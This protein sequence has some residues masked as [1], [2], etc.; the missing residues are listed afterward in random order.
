MFANYA[1]ADKVLDG[2]F[3]E[4]AVPRLKEIEE[5]VARPPR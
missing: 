5:F 4:W 3:I 2:K 1:Q